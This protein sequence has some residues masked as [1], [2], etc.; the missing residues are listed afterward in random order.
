MDSETRE[1]R[2]KNVGV[3]NNQRWAERFRRDRSRG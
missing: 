1:R 2:K 3:V